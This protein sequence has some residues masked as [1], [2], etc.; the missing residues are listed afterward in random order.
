MQYEIKKDYIILYNNI[1]ETKIVI[2]FNDNS[3]KMVLNTLYTINNF[4]KNTYKNNY[5]INF[6]RYN[7]DNKTKTSFKIK[8]PTIYVLNINLL[9]YIES[10]KNKKVMDVNELD[11]MMIIFSSKNFNDIEKYIKENK[12][13]DKLIVKLINSCVL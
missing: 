10:I 5:I 11:I 4:C 8:K 3:K 6:N 2:N 7:I 13:F 12:S 1:T 9:N